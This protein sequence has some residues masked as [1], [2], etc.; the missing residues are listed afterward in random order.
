MVI[1]DGYLTGGEGKRG[2]GEEGGEGNLWMCFVRWE[3][4]VSCPRRAGGG[5]V[6]VVTGGAPTRVG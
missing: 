6:Q 5:A 2:G 1:T 3:V 4:A